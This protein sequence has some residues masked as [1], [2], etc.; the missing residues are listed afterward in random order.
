MISRNRLSRIVFFWGGLIISYLQL[1]LLQVLSQC[2]RQLTTRIFYLKLFNRTCF[3]HHSPPLMVAIR[4]L[5]PEPSPIARPSKGW[6]GK[7]GRRTHHT[8]HFE[9]GIRSPIV[10]FCFLRKSQ[11]ALI[12][13]SSLSPWSYSLHLILF[14]SSSSLFDHVWKTMSLHNPKISVEMWK[15]LIKGFDG[16]RNRKILPWICIPVGGLDS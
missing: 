7:T 5:S 14:A 3:A 2:L 8:F 10:E 6:D 12:K 16:T 13:S 1:I 15:S 9:L 11:V 4:K